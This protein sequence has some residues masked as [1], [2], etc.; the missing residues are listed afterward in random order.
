MP[1]SNIFLLVLIFSTSV[2]PILSWYCSPASALVPNSGFVPNS[3][4]LRE[5]DQQWNQFF[6]GNQSRQAFSL[7]ESHLGGFIVTGYV[8]KSTS[9]L[10]DKTVWLAKIDAE[11]NIEWEHR[12]LE[13]HYGWGEA[14]IECKNDDFVLTG[15][16]DDEFST[17]FVLRTDSHGNPLWVRIFNFTQHQE[18]YDILELPSGNIVVCGWAWTYQPTNPID[19]LVICLDQSGVLLWHRRY[20]GLLEEQFYSLAYGH[21]GELVLTG[22]TESHGNPSAE[23]WIVKTDL[24]GNM[25]WN[26][27]FGSIATSRGCG[28]VCDPSGEL[29]IAGFIRDESDD[30]LDAFIIHTS[31]N[32]TQ[33]WNQTLNEELDTIAYAIVSC[34]DGGYAIAGKIS[35]S[36][37]SCWFDMLVIRVSD[38]G[39]ILWQKVYGDEGN[40]VGLSI[41]ECQEGDLVLAGSTS[42][43]GFIGG[44]AWLIRI[45]DAPPPLIDLRQVNL[46]MVIIGLTF[47]FI[48]LGFVASIYFISRREL[49]RRIQTCS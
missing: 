5:T 12:F 16:I 1:K 13:G 18:A 7:A 4:S 17:I 37:N 39:D 3:S 21:G 14:V 11:G 49:H 38:S 47:A 23:V 22:M 31:S 6:D 35:Q 36:A 42:S 45:T 9:G 20:G 48:V 32:G 24:Q 27:T 46:P 40:D 25:V 28:I 30:G 44:T 34:S 2:F 15:V 41:V 10:G 19:G 33:I 43:Y 26:T 8:I 29:T